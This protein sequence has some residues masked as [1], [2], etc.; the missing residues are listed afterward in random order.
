M[1]GIVDSD[2]V[3][4][5]GAL[6]NHVARVPTAERCSSPSPRRNEITNAKGEP[7]LY[8]PRPIEQIQ[9]EGHTAERKG[10]QCGKEGNPPL[11]RVS[12]PKIMVS[13]PNESYLQNENV[14]RDDEALS[15]ASPSSTCRHG[16]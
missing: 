5:L 9:R 12:T 16:G 14:P 2:E 10:V 15:T 6:K 1:K 3:E 8:E 11:Q 13:I 7:S 4:K